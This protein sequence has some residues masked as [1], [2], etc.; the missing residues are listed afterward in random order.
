MAVDPT[1]N[2]HAARRRTAKKH[3][4]LK[5]GFLTHL[6]VFLRVN[7]GFAPVGGPAFHAVPKAA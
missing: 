1:R 5:M 4:E 3:V 2:A 7:A 6:A